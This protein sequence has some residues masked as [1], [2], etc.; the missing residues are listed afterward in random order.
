V[1]I[2]GIVLGL[3]CF[4]MKEPRR[5]QSDDVFGA[6]P[7][8]SRKE[9]LVDYLI[10]LRTPS[11]VLDTLGMTAMT[12]A[13]GGIAAWVPGYLEQRGV[14]ELFGINPV[15]AF[16]GL[17]ALTGLA[18]TLLGGLIGDWLR[19]RFSGS[20]FLVSGAAMLMAFPMLLLVIWLPFPLA[21]IPLICTAFFL[22]FNTGPTN[23]ILA[24]VTHPLLRAPGFAFNILVIHVFGDVL[25]P[26]LMGWVSG[27]F[28]KNG[29]HLFNLYE[30]DV[31]F[32]L[33]SLMVLLGG[34]LWLWGAHYLERDTRRAAFSL[35][36]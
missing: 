33:V 5:G 13:M 20:Y 7:P 21:W 32:L 1:V 16:G 23:T 18:A 2:P 25:S 26:P 36:D 10:L 17:L 31:S 24:N 4:F 12:F 28:P 27:C 22:F 14:T 35:P 3:F 6:A 9:S 8:V 34:I 11:Y 15:T 19:P 29:L 30:L